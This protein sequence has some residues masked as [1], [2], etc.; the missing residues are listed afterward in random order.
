[1]I[2]HR[3]VFAL[4]LFMGTS[5]VFMQILKFKAHQHEN[6]AKNSVWTYLETPWQW[7]YDY[8]LIHSHVNFYQITGFFILC[9]VYYLKITDIYQEIKKKEEQ[10]KE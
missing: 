6:A 4:F 10:E 9:I 1:M 2:N 3:E 8:L 7:L 5:V